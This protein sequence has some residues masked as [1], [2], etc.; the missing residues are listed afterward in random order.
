MLIL[1][2]AEAE[3]KAVVPAAR[4]AVVTKRHTTEPRIVVPA[5]ATAH[6]VRA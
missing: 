2:K 3:T 4:I 1:R 5:A 6:T